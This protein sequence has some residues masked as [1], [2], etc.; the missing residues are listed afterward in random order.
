MRQ[1]RRTIY[2]G[3]RGVGHPRPTVSCAAL[4]T[5]TTKIASHNSC[6]GAPS[7]AEDREAT[8][9]MVGAGNIWIRGSWTVDEERKYKWQPGYVAREE[10]R[11]QWQPATVLPA[12]GGFVVLP[13][14]WDFP[15]AGR[16]TAFAAI[17]PPSRSH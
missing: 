13:G 16:G 5:G 17:Q 12:D 7:I 6:P 8:P 1:S 15:L 14:Y 9:S 2:D 3:K 4:A 10:A 11:Y